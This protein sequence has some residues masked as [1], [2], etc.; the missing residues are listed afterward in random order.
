MAAAD[1]S[2]HPDMASRLKNPRVI[3]ILGSNEICFSS[4]EILVT[5]LLEA[6]LP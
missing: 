1:W 5:A 3:E 6:A 2:W 4:P